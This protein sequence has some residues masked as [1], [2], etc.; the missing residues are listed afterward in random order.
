MYVC[1]RRASKCI[2]SK[3]RNRKIHHF[4]C[5]WVLN[6]LSNKASPSPRILEWVDNPFS[7]RSSRP[8]NWTGVFP[9]GSEVKASACNVGDLGSIPGLGRP[10]GEGNGNPLQYSCLENP[11]DGG[12]WWAI[13]HGVAKS[14]T[15]LSD[16]TFAF[17]L[18]H[19]RQIPYQLSYQ[20][21]PD[22]NVG[23]FN[24]VPAASEV[25]LT[26]FNFLFFPL[27]FIYFHHSTF[28]LTYPLSCLSYSTVGFLQIGSNLS[29][30][31]VQFLIDSSF[32][33]GPL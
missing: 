12:A 23:A 14:W 10:P 7:S 27:C 22:L 6:Q 30:W 21:S 19:C 2:K 32:L 18:L 3:R 9:G 17:F 26:S 16:L 24:I 33:L 15:W 8:R 29:Y 25:V 11:I 5:R 4:S 31:I 28:H 20:E 13:A 1:N